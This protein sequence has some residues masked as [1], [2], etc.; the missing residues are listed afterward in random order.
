MLTSMILV[1]LVLALRI[2]LALCPNGV[3]Q[4]LVKFQES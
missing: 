3:C 1:A 4:F 2:V